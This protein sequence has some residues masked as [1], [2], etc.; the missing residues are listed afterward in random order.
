[1]RLLEMGL[2]ANPIGHLCVRRD[3]GRMGRPVTGTGK[4]LLVQAPHE[5]EDQQ[6]HDE[7]EHRS[8]VRHEHLLSG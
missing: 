7:G 2:D 5:R 3:I 4:P 1:M 8:A 6:D